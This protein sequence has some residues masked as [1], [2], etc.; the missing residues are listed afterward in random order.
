MNWGRLRQLRADA[1]AGWLYGAASNIAV[2]YFR[3]N[4]RARRYQAE[5]W[6]RLYQASP[7]DTCHIALTEAALEH[8]WKVIERMPP[9]QH[10][11]AL[12]RWRCGYSYREISSILGMTEGTVSAHVSTARRTLINEVGPYLPFDLNKPQE[13]GS[14]S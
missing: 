8:C 4:E 9:R 12:L 3:S 5:V 6:H 10:A 11:A 14:Q 7:Q 2:N 1:L 13:G